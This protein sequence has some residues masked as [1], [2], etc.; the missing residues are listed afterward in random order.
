MVV[1]QDQGVIAEAALLR[2][3]VLVR[4]DR[5]DKAI[6]I[7]RKLCFGSSCHDEN[8][9][10][11]MLLG[12][13]YVRLG[14]LE[15]GVNILQ[16]A[17]A[18][19]DRAHPTIRSELAFNL[20]FAHFVARR[21]DDA[22]FALADVSSASDMIY[23]RA[24]DL[25]GWIAGARVHF[26]AALSWF[27]QACDAMACCYR[28]DRFAEANVLYGLALVSVELV[29]T[30]AWPSIEQRIA[31]FDWEADGL[32][33]S[34]CW[35]AIYCSMMCELL[36]D[37]IGAVAWARTAESSVADVGYRAFALCRSAAVFRGQHETL[38]HL[39]FT[40][41]ARDAFEKVNFRNQPTDQKLLPL[42]LAEEFALGGMTE[43]AA[44]L[45]NQ[46]RELIRPTLPE[47]VDQRYTILEAQVAGCVAESRGDRND[48][49]RAYSIA[50]QSYRRIGYKRRMAAVALR[51]ARLTG[52]A[53]YLAYAADA[54]KNADP[55]YW[56]V[57]ELR[58]L[59][60]DAAPALT[61]NQ[62]TI[63]ALVARGKTYKE[64]GSTLGRSWKTVN[65]SVEQLR[66]KFGAGTRGELVAEAM[67][68]GIVDISSGQSASRTA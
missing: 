57:R 7:L 17:A 68:R 58:A 24:L 27:Q 47:P 15:R 22:E 48:A 46:H 55:N 29:E 10:V 20:A 56:M 45:L 2:A 54:L 34:H 37:G 53:R 61:E 12:T 30:R 35:T 51:L 44:R 1:S 8:V 11:E 66:V 39:D 33:K 26:D 18:R 62:R 50:F 9:T 65:N 23:V 49:I 67:R 25:R 28:R 5:S 16:A 41:R 3:R 4:L 38:A 21:Y 40:I 59:T 6:E 42:F 63:L 19:A 14:Q 31:N 13:A 43:E 52:N 36:G 32:A 60:D 64:I